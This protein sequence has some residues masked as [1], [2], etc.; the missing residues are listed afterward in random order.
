M[1]ELIADVDRYHEF[2]PGC[3]ASRQ[4]SRTAEEVVGRI[5]VAKGP[6]RRHFTTRN[7][8][9]PPG[10]MDIELVDGPFSRLDGYWQIDPVG[11]QGSKVTLSLEFEFSSRFL[12]T[13]FAP[14]FRSLVEAMVDA[15]VRR[16]GVVYG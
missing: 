2:L 1:F 5:D 3:V 4:L 7:R 12:A 13:A 10:R 14:L 15:F 9:R 16:A 8:I 11:G 6:I